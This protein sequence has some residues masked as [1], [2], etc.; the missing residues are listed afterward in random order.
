MC[1]HNNTKLLAIV[2]L[3]VTGK[4]S[5]SVGACMTHDSIMDHLRNPSDVFGVLEVYVFRNP[6]CGVPGIF[7]ENILAAL[8][9]REPACG[10]PS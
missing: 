7:D 9:R 6:S 5:W 3:K 2:E 4:C 1:F 8:L 10:P